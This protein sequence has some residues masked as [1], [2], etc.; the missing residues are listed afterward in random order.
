MRNEVKCEKCKA[1]FVSVLGY[2]HFAGAKIIHLHAMKINKIFQMSRRE[3]E[4]PKR[5]I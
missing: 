5:V 2:S 3:C 1:T 4:Y